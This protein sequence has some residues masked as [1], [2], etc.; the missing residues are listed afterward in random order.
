M[1]KDEK[2]LTKAPIKFLSFLVDEMKT[3]NIKRILQKTYSFDLI[4]F[5]SYKL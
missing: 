2:K 4:H 5:R 1:K 3:K